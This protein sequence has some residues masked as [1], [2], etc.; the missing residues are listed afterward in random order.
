MLRPNAVSVL[1]MRVKKKTKRKRPERTRKVRPESGVETAQRVF[2][3]LLAKA[4][5]QAIGA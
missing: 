1:R 2:S 5:P 4:D 3:R